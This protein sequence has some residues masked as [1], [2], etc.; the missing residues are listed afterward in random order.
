MAETTVGKLHLDGII[1]TIYEG[2]SE[3][4]VSLALKEIGKG[5]LVTVFHD[6]KREL[7]E[8][9]EGPLTSLAARVRRGIERINEASAALAKDLNCAL[10]SARHIAEMVIHVI[11]ASELLRQASV[12]PSRLD[13]A[14]YWVNRKMLDVELNAKRVIECGSER[15]ERFENIIELFD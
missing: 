1:T 4:Q 12:S 3:I 8:L 2:T 5:A 13:L 15:I 9:Q 10:L 7:G 6:L 14:T 11:V